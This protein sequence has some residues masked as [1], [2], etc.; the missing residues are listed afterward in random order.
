ME[1]D[2]ASLLIYSY[3]LINW[4]LCVSSLPRGNLS[5]AEFPAVKETIM[6][7]EYELEI[8]W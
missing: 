1:E 6:E 5:V 2:K 8:I 3:R 4:V 7:R